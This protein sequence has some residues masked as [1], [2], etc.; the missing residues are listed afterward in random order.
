MA[1][2]VLSDV[3]KREFAVCVFQIGHPADVTPRK[4]WEHLAWK[5]KLK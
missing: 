5:T 4:L 3:V 1:A 2:A